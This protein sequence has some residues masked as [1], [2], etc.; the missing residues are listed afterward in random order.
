MEHSLHLG[1]G[2]V[3]AHV[4]PKHTRSGGKE[5]EP[6]SDSADSDGSSNILS[7]ALRKLLGL[8]WQLHI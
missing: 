6:S 3:L 5:D 8:I 4:T 1:A 7:G 2:H